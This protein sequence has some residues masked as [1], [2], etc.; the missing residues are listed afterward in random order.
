MQP[1]AGWKSARRLIPPDVIVGENVNIEVSSGHVV[2][3]IEQI[4]QCASPFAGIR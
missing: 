3:S 2:I 4:S 1:D